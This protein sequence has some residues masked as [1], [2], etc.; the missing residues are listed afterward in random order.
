MAPGVNPPA[1]IESE[2]ARR[3]TRDEDGA[4]RAASATEGDAMLVGICEAD[5]WDT[6]SP[7]A[8]QKRADPGT[9]AEQDGQRI[10]LGGF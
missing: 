9:S 1:W 2:D 7:Q 8:G 5:V 10:K 3:P 4:R 6:A